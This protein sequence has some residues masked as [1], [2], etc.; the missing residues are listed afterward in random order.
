[1][2]LSCLNSFR[3]NSGVIISVLVQK[4][5]TLPFASDELSGYDR[6][7]KW[8]PLYAV[9]ALASGT[10]SHRKFKSS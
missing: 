10:M 6:T 5:G 9:A 4:K 2:R 7:S 8:G 1:M 3:D